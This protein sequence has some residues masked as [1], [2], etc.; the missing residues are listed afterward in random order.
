MLAM[1]AAE[2]PGAGAQ[3]FPQPLQ[4]IEMLPQLDEPYY[5]GHERSASRSSLVWEDRC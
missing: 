3:A 2:V 4:M 5:G 1:G